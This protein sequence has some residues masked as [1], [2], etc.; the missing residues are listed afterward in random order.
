MSRR[1]LLVAQM[2]IAALAVVGLVLGVMAPAFAYTCNAAGCT[3]NTKFTEPS[4]LTNG[5][6]LTDLTGCTASY[7][8]AVDG[9]TPASP[10]SFTI[11]ASRPA[12]GGAIAVNNTDPTMVPG[13]VYTIAETVAC[14]ST[15]FGT[16]T[17]TPPAALPM[18]NGVT[19]NPAGGLTLQ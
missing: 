7:T 17:S 14:N 15:A 6:T 4:T 1:D 12:G 8:T 3:W 2:G 10:R 11:P 19:T 16:G 5:Q 9:G 18:N 13:H